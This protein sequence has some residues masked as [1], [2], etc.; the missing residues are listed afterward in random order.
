MKGLNSGSEIRMAKTGSRTKQSGEAVRRSSAARDV[1]SVLAAPPETLTIAE[2]QRLAGKTDRTAG[3]AGNALDFP[4]LGL[5]G[6]AGSLL[7]ELKKKQ[8]DADSYSGYEASVVE[9]LGDVLW[10]FANMA[11]RAGIDLAELASRLLGSPRDA[12]Q[13][14][15]LSDLQPVSSAAEAVPQANFESTLIRLAGEVGKLTADFGAGRLSGNQDVL[16]GYMES[17]FRTL[18]DAANDA[19]V[20]LAHAAH[21]NLH[22]I[23]DRWPLERVYPPLFD[24]ADDPSEQLPRRIK[25]QIFERTIND[26]TYVFLRCNDINIGDRLTDNKLEKDDYR[27]H[28]VFHLAYAAILGWSPVMR[29]LFRVKRKSRPEIDETEDGARAI[30]IEEGVSTWI[31]NHAEPL[32]F[33]ENLTSI[34]Y[35]LL[36]AV[37]ELVKGYEPEQCPLWLWEEAILKGYEVFRALRQHRR[38]LIVADLNERT[39]TF[40]KLPA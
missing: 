16:P 3:K 18:I 17:I 39:I 22:K 35:G 13:D 26:Q 12:A 9:E 21:S 38:G 24:E 28:D 6:E 7:S 23:F 27:F 19:A 1:A 32:N 29:A 30:L 2:Y 10:Y 5:F 40:E 20:S 8:R 15:T 37:R 25:M 33:F 36:K 4:L 14:L 34:D 31:F 11:S